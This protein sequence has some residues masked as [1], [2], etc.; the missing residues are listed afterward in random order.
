MRLLASIF[1]ISSLG[2]LAWAQIAEPENDPQAQAID[3]IVAN[4]V[5]KQAD[6]ERKDRLEF[7]Q[8]VIDDVARLCALDGRQARELQL[9]ALGATE[10]SMESWH[11]QAERYFFQ[12]VSE[13]SPD[14][15]K[16]M[17][18]SM[19]TVNFSGSNGD[20]LGESQSLWRETLKEV[21]SDQQIAL[22]KQTLASR[23]RAEV[24][25][26]AAMSLATIDNYLRLTPEQ[27]SQ[28][29]PIVTR[30]A[31]Y[32]LGEIKRTWGEYLEKN[33]LMSFALSSE[34]EDLQK[35]FSKA[36]YE[37]YK[38]ATANFNTFWSQRRKL[39]RAKEKA[40]QMRATKK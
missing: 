19:G 4:H 31:T 26:F 28:L 11:Q 12:R 22:Y 15:A 9:A 6:N 18:S 35:I 34:P 14:E 32:N 7:M 2:S 20:R 3:A 24:D 16:E 13:M 5:R 1:L 8:I 40:A 10:R 33:M 37:H 23:A 21:L 29:T 17:L 36:Q 25:A 27:R 39:Q 30:A 38:Q